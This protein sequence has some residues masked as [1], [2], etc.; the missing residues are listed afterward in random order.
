MAK[1]TQQPGRSVVQDLLEEPV[2]LPLAGD[3][4]VARRQ[5]DLFESGVIQHPLR[6]EVVHEGARL[7]TMETEIVPRKIH[8]RVK[9]SRCQATADEPRIEPISHARALK[10]AADDARQRHPPD[11]V[12]PG[13]QHQGNCCTSLILGEPG[14]DRVALSIHGEEIGG[15]GGLPRCQVRSVSPIGEREPPRIVLF[16]EAEDQTLRQSRRKLNGKR[17]PYT[18]PEAS[19]G[20][21]PP[22]SQREQARVGSDHAQ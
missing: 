16:E 20:R 4:Q 12:R 7:Q 22:P 19:C 17:H 8:G 9:D 18:L 13:D 3:L 5:A 11:Y 2:I 15:T 14:R 10:R 1:V 6:R 21:N